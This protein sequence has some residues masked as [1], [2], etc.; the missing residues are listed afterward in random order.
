MLASILPF[1]IAALGALAM[2]LAFPKTS[3]VVL[4]P[5]GATGL[6]WAWFGV[7]PKRAF[8]LGWLSGT[9]F[10][11]L[12]FAWFGET[13]GA[14][15]APFG[16]LL[17]LGPAIV[18]ALLGFALTGA[19]SAYLARSLGSR[20]RAARALVP[21]GAAAA[22]AFAEWLRS[23][24]LG[25]LGV[26]FGS[27]GY[28]QANSPAAPVAAFAG[29]YGL[30]FLICVLGAYAAYAIRLRGV[31]G[32]AVDTALAGTAVAVCAGTC[33]F[34][35]PARAAA[36][37]TFPVAA[38]QGNIAQAIKFRPSAF[39]VTFARYE[40]LTLLASATHPRLIV[41]P[42]TVMPVA[43]NRDP[44]LVTRLGELAKRVHAALVVGTLA[45]LPEGEY[46][47]LYVFGPSGE[48][49]TLYRKRQLV[50]FAEHLPFAPL[51]RRI[52]WTSNI[53]DFL[54]G[55]GTDV[56][57]AA[58]VHV[59]PV[60]C[61]ESDFSGLIRSD[62]RA[63]ASALV[64]ATDD[65]WFGTTAGPY[66]H[67]QT[68]QLRALESGRWIVRAASTGISGIIAPDGRY[69]QASKLGAAAIVSGKIGTPVTTP[70]VALGGG[71]LA[72]LFAALYLGVALLGRAKA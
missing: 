20:S 37:P 31:R 25:E 27:L 49:E 43:M 64:I 34:F 18:E 26:P 22:F 3:V 42:E 17:A 72:L 46:N 39:P 40:R 32:V 50:P 10:F 44:A 21:T 55:S 53:S 1:V 54:A 66:M 51:L 15:V 9:I 24:A 12:N 16:F 14:F 48:L 4:A 35:A 38:I 6:F 33:A 60:I 68:A 36:A 5:I 23:E 65:A 59:G 52:P 47:V 2:A 28:T 67:A 69:T 56:F 8:W 13:A 62:V 30:T 63:G 45:V 57:T 19:L 61:W 11:D 41:W 71:G 70:F 29:T 58:G 7:S